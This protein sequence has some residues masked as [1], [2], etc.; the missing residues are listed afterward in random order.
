LNRRFSS[1]GVASSN[2]FS[3]ERKGIAADIDEPR[4]AGLIISGPRHGSHIRVSAFFSQ[5]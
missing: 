2:F 5:E 4:G 1:A 3:L